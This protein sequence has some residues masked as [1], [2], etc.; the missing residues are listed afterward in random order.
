ML[1]APLGTEVYLHHHINLP[2]LVRYCVFVYCVV[3]TKY[4]GRI[5][6]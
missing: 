6:K 5:Y 4:N 2:G 1:K 3:L